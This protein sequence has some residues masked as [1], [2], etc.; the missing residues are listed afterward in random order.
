[1]EYAIS[2]SRLYVSMFEN[3]EKNDLGGDMEAYEPG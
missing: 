2:P 3:P 1:M